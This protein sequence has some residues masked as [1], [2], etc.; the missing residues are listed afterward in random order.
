M[1]TLGFKAR[2]VK[3]FNKLP[4]KDRT[5]IW[6]KLQLLKLEP[7]P[8]GFRKLVGKE[9]ELRVRFGNYRLIYQIDET[10]KKILIIQI[11][12]RKDIYR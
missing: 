7:R 1:F 6:D 2:V 4:I 5:K 12:H 9:N 3:D 8:K 10:M 11:G